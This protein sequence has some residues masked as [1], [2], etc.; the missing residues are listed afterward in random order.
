MAGWAS[1]MSDLYMDSDKT[2]EDLKAKL[3]KRCCRN[4]LLILWPEVTRPHIEETVP[5]EKN[6]WALTCILRDTENANR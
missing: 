1:R 2:E 4:S 6:S 5:K 3:R